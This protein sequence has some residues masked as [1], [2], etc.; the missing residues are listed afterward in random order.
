MPSPTTPLARK[1]ET[2]RSTTAKQL[3]R[4]E[5]V[6]ADVAKSVALAVLAD[7]NKSWLENLNRVD[8]LEK[9]VDELTLA[10]ERLVRHVARVDTVKEAIAKAKGG[11]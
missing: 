8:R 2:L 5:R 4:N 7:R 9:R 3:N 1:F 11:T 6:S 10:F